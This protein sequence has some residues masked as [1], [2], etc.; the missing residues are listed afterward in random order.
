MSN[1]FLLSL[2]LLLCSPSIL[3][4]FLFLSLSLSFI[5][6]YFFSSFYHFFHGN[7]NKF[8]TYKITSMFVIWQLMFI[9]LDI[10]L[11]VLKCIFYIVMKIFFLKESNFNQD[12]W[13]FRLPSKTVKSTI[14]R[15]SEKLERKW[16][17]TRKI[18]VQSNCSMT[19]LGL[20]LRD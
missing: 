4:L 5:I 2:V 6:L 11:I 9:L 15:L 3:L 7:A 14:L 16:P 19:M 8:I 20:T 10:N 18:V 1:I 13:T 12:D 17:F